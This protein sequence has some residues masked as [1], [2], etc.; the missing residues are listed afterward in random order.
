MKYTKS[1]LVNKLLAGTVRV[2]FVKHNGDN[3]EMYCTLKNTLI[4]ESK[5]PTSESSNSNDDYLPV[6]DLE[7]DD[8]RS[9]NVSSVS[10]VN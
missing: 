9:F 1:E 7:K 2:K 10:K 3:R 8:W 4:P 6:Y 5:R